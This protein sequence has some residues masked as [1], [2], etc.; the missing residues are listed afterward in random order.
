[1]NASAVVLAL[2]LA[3]A[4]TDD[5]AAATSPGGDALTADETIDE[6]IDETTDVAS[7]GPAATDGEDLPDSLPP[8][9]DELSRLLGEEGDEQPRAS[10]FLEGVR[11]LGE[12]RLRF[13]LDDSR[14]R[15]PT[16]DLTAGL[17][18]TGRVGLTAPVGE[19]RATL[20]VGDGRRVG[21]NFGL[22]P[23]PIVN[24]AALGLLYTAKLDLELAALFLPVT[25]SIGRFPFRVADGRWVGEAPFDPRGRTFDGAALAH[26]GDIVDVVVG[27]FYLGPYLDGDVADTSW[28]V[29]GELSRAA[30][31]YSFS[32][33]SLLHK[34][35][36]PARAGQASVA[37]L[38]GGMRTHVDGFGFR[39]AAGLD[40]QLPALET[41]P[42]SPA[43]WGA[44]AE[45]SA[46]YAPPV[47][48]WMPVGL[49]FLELAG[50]WTGGAPVAGRT[51][52]AP[53]PSPHAFLGVLDAAT[54]DNIAS[55]SARVGVF[56]DE[57]FLVDVE[58]RVIALAD[59][60][61]PMFDASG[62]AL[63]FGDA[64]R[65]ER[66]ALTE[67]DARVR[68]PM[69]ERA[70]VEGEYGVGFPGPAFAGG[71][72][73]IQRLLVSVWFELDTGG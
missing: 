51:F 7:E 3:G 70:G 67:V 6:T 37:A 59:P 54:A 8:L 39:L 27:G 32:A 25:A 43:G 63:I 2:C 35:G 20:L 65:T 33:Y 48:E 17:A 58:G 21:Q 47:D 61:G 12:G 26:R 44:H 23:S 31:W 56:S 53:G 18:L 13:E 41:A 60:T 15:Q 50:E 73:P 19:H 49:P 11:L 72:T 45:A 14:D 29:T 34:D 4:P 42:L 22:L 55:A 28:L 64:Q 52:R 10:S 40:G 1:M 68:L 36:T 38:T 9:D 16:N 66:L 30:E 5:G 57:G 46:R 24:P 69:A 71:T 62:R